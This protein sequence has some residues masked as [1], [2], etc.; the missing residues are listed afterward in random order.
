ML[1]DVSGT[2]LY[3]HP[4]KLSFDCR[5]SCL[6]LYPGVLP[7]LLLPPSSSGQVLQAVSA[8]RQS[9]LL[10]DAS[11]SKSVSR[12]F[13]TVHKSHMLSGDIHLPSTLHR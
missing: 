10:L 11:T 13:L 1:D 8:C 3:G 7:P 12:A 2:V 6:Y 5:C 4:V 9:P